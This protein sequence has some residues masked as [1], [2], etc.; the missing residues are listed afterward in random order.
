MSILNFK[1][2]VI[3]D[4][5]EIEKKLGR[6]NIGYVVRYITTIRKDAYMFNTC[7][8]SREFTRKAESDIK[9]L[10]KNLA[11]IYAKMTKKADTV[12]YDED[13][14]HMYISDNP[15]EKYGYYRLSYLLSDSQPSVYFVFRSKYRDKF[16]DDIYLG[17]LEDFLKNLEKRKNRVKGHINLDDGCKVIEKFDVITMESI[18]YDEL[19]ASSEEMEELKRLITQYREDMQKYQDFLQKLLKNSCNG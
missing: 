12:E 18:P 16:G 17:D 1:Q 19:K 7:I 4:Q 13:Y 3:S 2:T 11:G 8:Y 5:R 9:F 10:D 14:V 6:G 15:Y